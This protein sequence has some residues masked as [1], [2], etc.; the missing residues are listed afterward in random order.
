MRLATPS[1]FATEVFLLE[2]PDKGLLPD[3]HWT[4]VGDMRLREAWTG[5]GMPEPGDA[6]WVTVPEEEKKLRTVIPWLEHWARVPLHRDATVVALGGGVVSDLVGL[7]AALYLRGVAWQ[8]W[9]TT[10]LAMADASLGGK[11]GADLAAGKNLV[12]AFHPPKRLVACTGFLKD[13]PARHL[14]NGRWEL[15]KTALILGEMAWAMEMLQDGPVRFAWVERALAYKAGVVH[16][17]P[18]EAGERRLLNL[19]HTLGHALE[20][21]SGYRLLHGEAVGLGLLGACLLAEEQGL[22]SFPPDLLDLLVRRLTPLAPLIAP[23]P[24]CLPLLHRDKKAKR[25]SGHT[26][27]AP[28]TEIHC[29]LP[30]PGESAIQRALAPRVWEVPHARL[31]DLLDREAHRA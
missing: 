7:G 22:K 29:I 14:E 1:G 18:R 9:P 30:R 3:G 25:A 28:A 31:I 4:L 5:A 16:R 6:L 13:L 17:D 23:W 10:L 20:A 21:A 27:E 8:V 24:A 15:I 19:G 2:A 26:E 12:G 11:T